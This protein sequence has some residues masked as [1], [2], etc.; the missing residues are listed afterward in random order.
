MHGDQRGSSLT[1][2]VHGT[3]P[4][5]LQVTPERGPDG[6][7][8]RLAGEMD[9]ATAHQLVDIIGPLP[10]PDLRRVRLDLAELVFIDASGLTALRQVSMIV[11]GRGGRLTLHG[12][13]PLLRR[14]LEITDLGGDFDVET[15]LTAP[16]Q[17]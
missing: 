11:A 2:T 4:A 6:I 1:P 3:G 10:A 7:S 14:L 12:V 9:I 8:L 16:S 15:G 5:T 13:Q 17:R